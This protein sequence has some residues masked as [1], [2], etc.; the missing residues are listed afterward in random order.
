MAN[1]E[2]KTSGSFETPSEPR[3]TTP[4]IPLGVPKRRRVANSGSVDGNPSNNPKK[5]SNKIAVSHEFESKASSNISSEATEQP[6]E[7]TVLS[8]DVTAIAWFIA[9][10]VN[11]LV[12]VV[13]L[14][15]GFANVHL[16]SGFNLPELFNAGNGV[17]TVINV[18]VS[19][20]DIK[21]AIQIA[22]NYI[23][24]IAILFVLGTIVGSVIFSRA[25]KLR[26]QHGLIRRDR[27]FATASR[28]IAALTPCIYLPLCVITILHM[29]LSTN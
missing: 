28:W 3:V 13:G 11:L 17:G 25:G 5:I 2:V 18:A 20:A 26:K 7:V 6:V 19:Q 27:N 1:R 23:G 24:L 12:V 22:I 15:I 29:V 16:P 10:L 9:S 21:A 8:S 4:V 14:L